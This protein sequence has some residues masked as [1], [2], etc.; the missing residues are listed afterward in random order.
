MI[1]SADPVLDTPDLP[2]FLPLIRVIGHECVVGTG[3]RLKVDHLRYRPTSS[4]MAARAP[5]AAAIER[6]EGLALPPCNARA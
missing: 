4:I 1:A 2:G 6:A 5:V 3:Q